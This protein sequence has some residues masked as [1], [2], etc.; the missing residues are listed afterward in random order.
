MP[1]KKSLTGI[2]ATSVKVDG[3][4]V[5]HP[6]NPPTVTDGESATITTV[7]TQAAFDAAT[8]GPLELVVLTSA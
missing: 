2:D 4:E 6:G 3:Q 5:F 1:D 7:T 8:P